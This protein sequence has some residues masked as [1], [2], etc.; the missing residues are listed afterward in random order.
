M[1][2][3]NVL[4]IDDEIKLTQ[5]LAFTLR[6]AGMDC[7]Q[8]HNGTDGCKIAESDKPDVILLD[9]RMP[10]LSGIEVLERLNNDVP[11]IPVIMMSAFDDTKDAVEAIKMGAVDY[12]SKPFDVDELIHLIQDTSSRRQL[13]SEVRYLRDRYTNDAAFI[14]HSPLIK[15]LREQIKRVA[16]SQ[17]STLLLS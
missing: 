14:G 6:Q 11:D 4:I 16:S 12:L 17:I 13:E 8:A 15:S 9:I 1:S 10:G 2:E 7:I 5:S 3:I